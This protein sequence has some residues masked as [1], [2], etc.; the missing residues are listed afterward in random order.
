M[1]HSSLFPL[2]CLR[3]AYRS[4][5]PQRGEPVPPAERFPVHQSCNEVN[6]RRQGRQAQPASFSSRID[7]IHLE[8]GLH[9]HAIFSTDL[10]QKREGFV[11]AAEHHMLSVID[12]LAGVWIVECGGAAA[13]HRLRLQHGHARA[14]R[15][16]LHGGAETGHPGTDDDHV[17]GLHRNGAI[18]FAHVIAAIIA[19]RGR[20]TR[21]RSRNTSYPARSIE[22]S[23]WK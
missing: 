13:E 23:S 16:Q 2:P 18:T 9:P 22:R 7:K 20:P 14:L 17:S 6:W 3:R 10:P 19:W 8:A 5:E 21:T 11:I 12:A 4:G 1:S 15:R